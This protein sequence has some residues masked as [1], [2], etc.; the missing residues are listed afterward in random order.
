MFYGNL[1][2]LQL[3]PKN[4]PSNGLDRSEHGRQLPGFGADAGAVMITELELET[5]LAIFYSS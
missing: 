1:E 3:S 4:L 5:S 2:S